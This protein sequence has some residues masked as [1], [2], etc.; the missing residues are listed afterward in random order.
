MGATEAAKGRKCAL[1][2]LEMP[3]GEKRRDFG[4]TSGE[5]WWVRGCG[6]FLK[7]QCYSR[8]VEGMFQRDQDKTGTEFTEGEAE[9]LKMARDYE[10]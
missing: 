4:Y 10:E 9:F 6:H 1:G 8:D 7:V 5:N 2:R 3:S